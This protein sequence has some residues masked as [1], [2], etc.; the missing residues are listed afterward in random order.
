MNSTE[1]QRYESEIY[2]TSCAGSGKDDDDIMNDAW[3]VAP[4]KSRRN[5]QAA[6]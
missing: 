3:I 1:L 6:S 2:Y 4:W 5:T